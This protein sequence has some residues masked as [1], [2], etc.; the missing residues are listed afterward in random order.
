MKS[1]IASMRIASLFTLVL[2]LCM[3]GYAHAA[4][5]C[6]TARA[7]GNWS[8]TDNGT[9]IGIGPR[10]AIG[11]LTLDAAGNVTNGVATS[12]LDGG[13]A[14]ETFSG[15]YTVNPD[16]TGTINVNIYSGGVE[17]F[18]VTLNSSFDQNVTHLRAIFTSITTPGGVALASVINLDANKQ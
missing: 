8:F 7:A 12:S 2:V 4:G 13:V 11:T 3:A 10:T 6:S 1:S 17:L 18:A 5:P 9:V 15:T 14:Q 16:C